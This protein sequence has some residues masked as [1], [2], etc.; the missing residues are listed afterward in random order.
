MVQDGAGAGQ[1]ANVQKKAVRRETGVAVCY[2][3]LRSCDT[4][5]CRRTGERRNRQGR[6]AALP[7]D[8]AVLQYCSVLYSFYL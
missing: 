1:Y 3:A 7:G 4:F 6:G 5:H 8:T 2:S